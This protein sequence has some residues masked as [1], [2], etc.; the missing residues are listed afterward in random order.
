MAQTSKSSQ[1]I[2]VLGTILLV[3]AAYGL[4]QQ[5]DA[6]SAQTEPS[7]RLGALLVEGDADTPIDTIRRLQQN[8]KSAVDKAAQTD[9]KVE[10]FAETTTSKLEA[11][12]ELLTAIRDD[13]NDEIDTRVGS[14][15]SEM[16]N[17]MQLMEGRMKQ[18]NTRDY[19]QQDGAAL[20]TWVEIAPLNA[21][22]MQLAQARRQPSDPAIAEYALNNGFL[23]NQTTDPATG[24]ADNT[25]PQSIPVATIPVNS[26]LLNSMTLSTLIGRVPKGGQVF[27]PFNF[28][29]QTGIDNWTSQDH[30][31]PYLERAIWRGVA[32]GDK[33]L[34][35]IRGALV[36]V[37][38][39]F[40]D[41]TIQTVQGSREEP[42]AELVST[43]GSNCV[44]GQYVSNT[45]KYI[46]MYGLGGGLAGLGQAISEN[47]T[48]SSF[49]ASGSLI[50]SVNGDT[51]NFLAGKAL[52]AS[53]VKAAEIIDDEYQNSFSSVVLES[54][55]T[56]NLMALRQIDIDYDPQGRK[57]RYYEAG[58]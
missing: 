57:V 34:E 27:E 45:G 30:D 40:T 49:T 5:D 37:T 3:A 43:T 11:L 44:P 31:I 18:A 39:V 56:V 15:K 10:R 13:S 22:P 25:E 14:M 58:Q 26:P 2:G 12:T 29:I 47:E 24:E 9:Q 50:R 38:F 51:G 4:T 41:E 52:S 54:G 16:Q 23:L 33:D 42:L 1:L 17:W 46:A 19:H 32:T 55:L 8:A 53:A 28:Y 35:C 48:V 20:N 36:S 7:K 6:A 21:R